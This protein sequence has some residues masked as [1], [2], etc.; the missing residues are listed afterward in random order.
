MWSRI[1]F[2]KATFPQLHTEFPVLYGNQILLPRSQEPA[3]CFYPAP[4]QSNSGPWKRF[5]DDPFY[6]YPLFCM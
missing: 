6:Y 3:T 5:I 1:P 4:V 2:D